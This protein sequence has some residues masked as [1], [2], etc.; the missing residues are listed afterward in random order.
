MS[1]MYKEEVPLYG[2]L[3]ELVRDTNKPLLSTLSEREA[4]RLNQE[5][6]GV[7]EKSP[8]RV[9]RSSQRCW[10]TARVVLNGILC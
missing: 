6:H 2:T 8:L 4:S 3:I 5:R 9:W 7:S 10:E 1:D